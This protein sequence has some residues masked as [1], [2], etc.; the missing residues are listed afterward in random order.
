MKKSKNILL[1][2]SESGIGLQIKKDLIN[3][4]NLFCTTS[5]KVKNKNYLNFKEKQSIKKSISKAY[6]KFPF[7]DYIIFNSFISNKRKEFKDYTLKKFTETI[8]TNISA[9]L[10]ISKLILQNYVCIM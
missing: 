3:R 10:L 1:I 8:N 7:Y 9:H 4:N 6:K 5:K 2:G